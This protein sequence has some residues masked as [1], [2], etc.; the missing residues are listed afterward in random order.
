MELSSI[1]DLRYSQKF[2]TCNDKYS[3]GVQFD[4]GGKQKAT[5]N[6]AIQNR[7]YFRSCFS[8]EEM[9]LR[10][11][12]T[13]LN[14]ILQFPYVNNKIQIVKESFI[15]PTD[16]CFYLLLNNCGVDTTS[17]TDVYKHIIENQ[18][19]NTYKG[20]IKNNHQLLE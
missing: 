8:T 19:L 1:L 20:I 16:R 6:R 13:F 18:W 2:K 3:K 4:S 11:E 7:E 5:Y 12:A 15:I 10:K 17:A 14:S 9:H